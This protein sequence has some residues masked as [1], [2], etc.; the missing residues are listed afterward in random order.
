MAKLK[1]II[2]FPKIEKGRILEEKIDKNGNKYFKIERGDDFINAF[3]NNSR[4]K[5]CNCKVGDIVSYII[6]ENIKENGF[7]ETAIIKEIEPSFV[8]K[9]GSAIKDIFNL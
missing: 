2:E 3:E 5:F 9:V 8:S 7:Y 4:V 6:K 1:E